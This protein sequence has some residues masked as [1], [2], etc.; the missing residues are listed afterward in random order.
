MSIFS[1]YIGRHH[2]DHVPAADAAGADPFERLAD[3]RE[4]KTLTPAEAE[5]DRDAVMNA[6]F[7]GQGAA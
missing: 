5:A 4:I 3:R 1:R 7:D 2:P 6:V